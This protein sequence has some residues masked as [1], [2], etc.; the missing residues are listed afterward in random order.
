MQKDATQPLPVF[1]CVHLS[2]DQNNKLEIISLHIEY[3]LLRHDCVIVPGFGAFIKSRTAARYDSDSDTWFPM[4]SEIRFNREVN[5]D[6][7][8]LVNSYSRKY[9]L[10]FHDARELLA[11]DIHA[12]RET[13]NSDGE[14]A[15]G[16]IGT[17]N[18]DGERL[19]FHPFKNAEA[20][21]RE[22]GFIPVRAKSPGEQPTNND[23]EASANIEKSVRR[24]D[25][26]RYYNIRVNRTFVK[27]AAS[28]LLLAV[29]ALSIFI[30][31]TGDRQEDR[32]SVVPVGKIVNAA[33]TIVR[34]GS[35]KMTSEIKAENSEPKEADELEN[36]SCAP[37]NNPLENST[38]VDEPEYFLI[39]ATFKT[40]KEAENFMKAN[41][42]TYKLSIA[43]SK[44]LY[45]VSAKA[46]NDKAELLRE[47][48][49]AA[50]NNAFS[51][52]WIW[53]K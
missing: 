38:A 33:E 51:E 23:A 47:L 15:V 34:D 46:G 28:L 43:P 48:N 3:L 9:R 18:V 13:L 37:S 49:S 36:I 1:S 8:L 7:G 19:I 41:Q 52:A 22:L 50:F 6:D 16:R 20:S 17:I 24:N 45:R 31:Y 2:A 5:Q 39:V 21:S 4:M 14:I 27:V 11:R 10:S 35:V 26:S 44:T 25:D 42:S 32:A 53:K 30:P 12:L 40:E 29:V